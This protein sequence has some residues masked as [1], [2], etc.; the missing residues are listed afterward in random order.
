MT[1]LAAIRAVTELAE[2]AEA[3]EIALKKANENLATREATIASLSLELD[4]ASMTIGYLIEKNQEIEEKL[5]AP[6]RGML[7]GKF[8]V[9]VFEV[10][11]P[12]TAYRHSP[13]TEYEIR[14]N[15]RHPSLRFLTT[16]PE[17]ETYE[18]EKI[19]DAMT[20]HLRTSLA[21]E[22]KKAAAKRR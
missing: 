15:P 21:E 4:S 7:D 3:L 6:F 19:A 18:A 12:V 17:L 10:K 16:E 9:D 14:L 1:K 20:K 5:Y 13:E 8:D 11:L 2:H 22:L